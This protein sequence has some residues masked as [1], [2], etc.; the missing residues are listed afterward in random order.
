MNSMLDSLTDLEVRVRDYVLGRSGARRVTF[1]VIEGIDCSSNVSGDLFKQ[2]EDFLL[3]ELNVDDVRRAGPGWVSPRRVHG[4]LDISLF[5]KQPMDKLKYGRE[6]EQVADW[7]QDQ[8]ISGIRFRSFVPT[9]AV[10]INGF[11]AY[12][13]V[14][15]IDFE[16]H[17][18]R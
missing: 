5:T 3:F 15:N 6:L 10:P 9:P 11:T 7:F 1:D 18:T 14:I 17:L 16:I 12:N 4:A 2:D 8:T 13:G